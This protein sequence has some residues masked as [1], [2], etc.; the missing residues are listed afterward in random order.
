[1]KTYVVLEDGKITAW[2]EAEDDMQANIIAVTCGYHAYGE[3][4]ELICLADLPKLD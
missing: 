2:L 1:M 3:P 4:A